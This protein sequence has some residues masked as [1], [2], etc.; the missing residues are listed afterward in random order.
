M[1]EVVSDQA[2]DSDGHCPT[3]EWLTDDKVRFTGDC[4][5][6]MGGEL[7]LD[8]RDDE[9]EVQYDAFSLS[10]NADG[11]PWQYEATGSWTYPWSDE[12]DA[13]IHVEENRSLTGDT[14]LL[15][16]QF[17]RNLE[18]DLKGNGA[19]I[20]GAVSVKQWADGLIGDFCIDGTL[21]WRN[22]CDAEPRGTVTYTAD[23]VIELVMEGRDDCDGCGALTIPGQSPDQFC[24]L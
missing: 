7:L 10:F 4:G 8:M 20:T 23:Q 2:D 1:L 16:G 19:K 15:S 18:Y 3:E 11:R 22:S 6:A 5:G 21:R 14:G 12:G 13:S 24:D 17:S 9:L